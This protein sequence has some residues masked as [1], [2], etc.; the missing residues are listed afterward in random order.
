MRAERYEATASGFPITARSLAVL[1]RRQRDLAEGVAGSG[2]AL[3][4]LATSRVR[5]PPSVQAPGIQLLVGL[6]GQPE[7]TG[8]IGEILR[9]VTAVLTSS[10][11]FRR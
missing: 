3:V 6:V 5:L 10:G 7:A 9:P 8:R 1:A 4:D 2:V 11:S